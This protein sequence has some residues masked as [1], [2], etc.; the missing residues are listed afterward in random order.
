MCNGAELSV[1]LGSYEEFQYTCSASGI[2]FTIN[3]PYYFFQGRKVRFWI[4]NTSN[5]A[6]GTITWDTN[7]KLAGSWVQPASTKRR[8][9]EFEYIG[10]KW[11]E[12]SRSVADIDN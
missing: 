7:Y 2:N 3:N 8:T 10:T 4:I 5:G 12:V 1:D 6:L 11:Y 9:I